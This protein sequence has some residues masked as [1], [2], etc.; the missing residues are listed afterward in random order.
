MIMGDLQKMPDEGDRFKDIVVSMIK[1][2]RHYVRSTSEGQHGANAR[3]NGRM[4][5][6]QRVS[7]KYQQWMVRRQMKR[8][9]HGGRGYNL[10]GSGEVR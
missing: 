4:T 9:R 7:S 8:R 10:H 2:E 5:D 3:R 6:V 1:R